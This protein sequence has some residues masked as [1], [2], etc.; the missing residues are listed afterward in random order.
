MKQDKTRGR[1]DARRV[2]KCSLM[3]RCGPILGTIGQIPSWPRSSAADAK[4][5]E[6]GIP[7]VFEPQLLMRAHLDTC[8][9][10]HILGTYLMLHILDTYLMLHILD[11]YLTLRP[12]RLH[13]QVYS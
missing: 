13:R 10:L 1:C 4:V 12:S 6:G 7:R 2:C 9:V 8:L 11:T 3:L 5:R